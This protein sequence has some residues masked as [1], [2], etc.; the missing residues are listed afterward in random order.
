MKGWYSLPPFAR[1]DILKTVEHILLVAKQSDGCYKVP[2]KITCQDYYLLT[3]FHISTEEMHITRKSFFDHTEN[4]DMK[5]GILLP[6][7][8]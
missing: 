4:Q 5:S 2:T 7:F 3:N 1:A 6:V 8:L